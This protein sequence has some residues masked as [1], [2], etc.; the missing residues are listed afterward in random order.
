MSGANVFDAYFIVLRFVVT[1]FN[2]VN[3]AVNLDLH[4][5]HWMTHTSSVI[6]NSR[7][8]LH[9]PEAFPKL[10]LVLGLKFAPCVQR[11]VCFFASQRK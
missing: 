9:I 11:T 2:I 5:D 1:Q 10:H 3:F 4:F 6:P 7:K 8:V